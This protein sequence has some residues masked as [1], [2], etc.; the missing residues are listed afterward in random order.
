MSTS[1]ANSLSTNGD[2]LF[3]MSVGVSLIPAPEQSFEEI[4]IQDYIKSYTTTGQRPPPCPQSPDTPSARAALG[5]PPLFVPTAIPNDATGISPSRSGHNSSTI[6]N[7]SDLPTHPI[8]QPTKDIL[9][10]VFQSISAQTQFSW[11]SHE[12]LRHY[13]YRAGNITAPP[14]S[15]MPSSL[16]EGINGSQSKFPFYAN[17]SSATAFLTSTAIPGPP[18]YMMCISASPRFDKH[19]FEELRIAHLLAGKELGSS[20]IPSR[21]GLPAQAA[22]SLIQVGRPRAVV[23]TS[24]VRGATPSYSTSKTI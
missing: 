17:D 20:E 6:R 13:A 11:F 7:P 15:S 3:F 2:L 16:T 8:F 23:D 12:E 1:T 4:R 9:G 18:D 10:E 5:L 19:S 21:G 24:A 14:S 22:P